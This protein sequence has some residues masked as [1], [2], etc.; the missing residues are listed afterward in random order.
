MNCIETDIHTLSPLQWLQWIS[1]TL[2]IT[3]GRVVV[4]VLL[5]LLGFPQ[6]LKC[7][8][9]TSLNWIPLGSEGNTHAAVWH[10]VTEFSTILH[11]DVHVHTCMY[12]YMYV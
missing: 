2:S 8:D 1:L 5:R 11:V 10:G 3:I 7:Y 6:P 12:M 4:L 9:L